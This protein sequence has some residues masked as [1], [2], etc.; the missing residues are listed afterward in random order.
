MTVVTKYPT[1]II[2][3][4]GTWAN[5]SYGLGAP[6]AQCMY[7]FGASGQSKDIQLGTYGFD[8]PSG[9]TINHVYIG[10]K[11]FRDHG[12]MSHE[13]SDLQN[14]FT[15]GSTTEIL[16]CTYKGS[17]GSCANVG[18]DE[19][20]IYTT[21]TRDDLVNETFSTV[22]RITVVPLGGIHKGYVDA[23]WI[24]VDYTYYQPVT[25]KYRMIMGRCAL[26]PRGV[27]KKGTEP[28]M[29]RRP[30]TIYTPSVPIK[31]TESDI[32]ANKK[33]TCGK[34]THRLRI[35]YKLTI[36]RNGQP[37][38]R[39][40]RTRDLLVW[41]GQMVLASLLSQGA[42]GTTTSTW[43]LV[44][45][46]NSNAPNM[47]DDSGNPDANEFNPLLGS[48]VNVSYDF[49]PSQKPSGEYQAFA[50]LIMYGT[51]TITSAGTLRK[52]GIRDTVSTPNRHIIVEDRVVDQSVQVNDQIEI[53]YW[54]QLW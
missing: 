38:K 4:S 5:P 31:P 8:I 37:I 46:S 19:Q 28:T 47:S 16:S 33:Y 39:F 10:M 1:A 41:R 35:L 32:G 22:C 40:K 50:Q 27:A 45:S 54:L 24:K 36:W 20:E 2:D 53:Y 15:K 9:A 17:S 29:A 12:S 30:S 51:I 21:L 18:N 14:R 52:I 44:A 26:R 6:D 25:Y 34:Q 48:A 7:K 23:I 43:Q 3:N 11:G 49:D 13:Y 42:L